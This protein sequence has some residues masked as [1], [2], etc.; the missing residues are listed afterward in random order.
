[1]Q[2][3]DKEV[4]WQC[5]FSEHF[6]VQFKPQGGSVACFRGFV[7]NAADVMSLAE[8]KSA[9]DAVSYCGDIHKSA[10]TLKDAQIKKA[11][12]V[13]KMD[14]VYR[15]PIGKEQVVAVAA[16]TEGILRMIESRP[17]HGIEA[18]E[19]VLPNGIV[20]GA[21]AQ[22]QASVVTADRD[23]GAVMPDLQMLAVAKLGFCC[24]DRQDRGNC[25]LG[26]IH[27]L[28]A[29]N[30]GWAQ[31]DSIGTPKWDDFTVHKRF[32]IWEC[33]SVARIL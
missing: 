12:I 20:L 8:V 4:L 6:P 16:K 3:F 21:L 25:L 5:G 23:L 18:A 15:L 10:G 28:G 29:E 19:Y 14:G 17:G 26:T 11:S 31:A 30:N 7:V 22:V 13:R 9:L 24:I 2:C 32:S 33:L 1:M 27:I